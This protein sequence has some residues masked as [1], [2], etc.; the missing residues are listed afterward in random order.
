MGIGSRGA[1]VSPGTGRETIS[2]SVIT[3]ISCLTAIN[4]SLSSSSVR[5]GQK[6]SKEDHLPI[7]ESLSSVL[8]RVVMSTG[9]K[10]LCEIYYC[11]KD[12]FFCPSKDFFVFLP[13]IF[14]F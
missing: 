4:S 6:V 11:I 2:L 8:T 1:H 13:Q 10:R 5:L 12:V 14:I 3:I 9:K 7:D